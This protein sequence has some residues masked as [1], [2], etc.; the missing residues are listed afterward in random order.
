MFTRL[1][2]SPFTKGLVGGLLGTALCL[3]VAWMGW[4]LYQTDQ[5]ARAAVGWINQQVAAQQQRGAPPK[6]P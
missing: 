1:K 5:L 6:A 3:A 2:D 4:R